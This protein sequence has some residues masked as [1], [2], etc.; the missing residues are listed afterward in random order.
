MNVQEVNMHEN[1]LRVYLTKEEAVKLHEWMNS[2][3]FEMGKIGAFEASK[4][5]HA[6][7]EFA[8]L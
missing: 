5:W 7:G 6:L 1:L 2:N 3:S 4:L 8:G